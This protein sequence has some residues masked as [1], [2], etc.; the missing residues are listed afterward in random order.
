[1]LVTQ[2]KIHNILTTVYVVIRAISLSL[3][4]SVDIIFI[5]KHNKQ[6][7]Q[8][9]VSPTYYLEILKINY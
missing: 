5:I 9:G 6:C 4:F 2:K 7:Q 8:L 3:G 1:M